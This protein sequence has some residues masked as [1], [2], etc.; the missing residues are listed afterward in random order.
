MNLSFRLQEV[1]WFK[2]NQF[3]G[4]IYQVRFENKNLT[5]KKRVEL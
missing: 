4:F 5:L 1:I 3:T 2:L